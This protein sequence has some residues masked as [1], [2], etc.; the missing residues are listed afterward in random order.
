M[1]ND[2]FFLNYIPRIITSPKTRLE[3][4]SFS[5]VKS[6]SVNHSDTTIRF[7]FFITRE[8][9]RITNTINSTWVCLFTFYVLRNRNRGL[10]SM[11]EIHVSNSNNVFTDKT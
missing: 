1:G 4:K 7:V 3:N 9:C 2:L 8:L 5:A 6:I 11:M 10:S